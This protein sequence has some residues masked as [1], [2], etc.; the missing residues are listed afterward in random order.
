MTTNL[1]GPAQI[2]LESLQGGDINTDE[3]LTKLLELLEEKEDPTQI[4][5]NLAS[6]LY[7]FLDKLKV[8]EHNLKSYVKDSKEEPLG[9]KLDILYNKNT[10]I[11]SS[12]FFE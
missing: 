1:L 12:K 4:E 7:Q 9:N 11:G 6:S 5:I 10:G 8:L 3:A 2:L